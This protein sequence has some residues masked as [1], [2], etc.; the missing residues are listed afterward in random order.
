MKKIVE[1]VSE[2]VN[3]LTS[4]TWK[5]QISENSRILDECEK[6]TIVQYCDV[7]YVAPD[8]LPLGEK[9]TDFFKAITR[10]KTLVGLCIQGYYNHT[11]QRFQKNISDDQI[12]SLCQSLKFN[13]TLTHLDLSSNEISDEGAILLAQAFS[14]N[15]TLVK[16]N[17]ENNFIHIDGISALARCLLRNCSISELKLDPQ[18]HVNKITGTG[19]NIDIQFRNIH[20]LIKQSLLRKKEL[21]LSS[22]HPRNNIPFF[23]FLTDEEIQ[24]KLIP[25]ASQSQGASQFIFYVKKQVAN[26][27]FVATMNKKNQIIEKA[28]FRDDFG[29]SF[30]PTTN[31]RG[32]PSLFEYC[33]WFCVSNKSLLNE[34]KQIEH[35]ETKLKLRQ[36]ELLKPLWGIAPLPSKEYLLKTNSPVP[37]K[38]VWPTLSSL[39]SYLQKNPL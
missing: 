32:V 37:S 13:Q 11:F 28:I 10:N 4:I 16:I 30:S 5:L 31:H 19:L 8:L 34:L 23:G 12:P 17:L 29:Y 35:Y 38:T 9:G 15:Q 39:L 33:G 24:K 18:L 20:F 6:R 27:L 7:E 2:N 25:P 26:T 1:I 14:I 3:N 22:S 36:I 21:Q